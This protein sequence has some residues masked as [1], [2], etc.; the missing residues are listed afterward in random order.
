MANRL[1]LVSPEKI[2]EHPPE[3][4]TDSK[5]IPDGIIEGWEL[6]AP[7]FD[8]DRRIALGPLVPIVQH[9]ENLPHDAFIEVK[10]YDRDQSHGHRFYFTTGKER[11]QIQIRPHW[12]QSGHTLRFIKAR[13]HPDAP[14]LLI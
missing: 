2:V 9:E 6:Y 14:E 7:N 11:G 4:P 12:H 1:F 3:L 5:L 10:N 8:G 13:V